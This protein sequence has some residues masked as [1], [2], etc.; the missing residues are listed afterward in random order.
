MPARAVAGRAA[1]LVVVDEFLTALESGPA[2]LILEGEPGI[3]KTTLWQATVELARERGARV[4][5]SRP[6]SSE[7]RLTFAGLGDLLVDVGDD[8]IGALPDP[9]RDALEVALLRADPIGSSSERRVVSTA[10]LGT[11]LLLAAESPVLIA[12]DDLQ[13]LDTASRR[14]LDFAVRRLVGR[15]VGVLTAIRI[16]GTAGRRAFADEGSERIRLGPLSLAS[17]HEVLK[18]ELGRTF[19][20]PTLVRIEATSSGNPFFAV[21]LARALVERGEALHGSAPLPVPDDLADLLATRLRRLPARTR[22]ALLVAATLSAPTLDTIDRASLERAKAAGVVRID[23]R[24][25]VSF[26]HPLLA[27]SVYASAGSGERRAVHAEVADRASSPEE[28]ARHRA[29]AAEEPDDEVATELAAAARTARDRGAPDGAVELLELACDLTPPGERHALSERRLDLGRYLSETGD[30]QRALEVLRDVAD[31]AP[32]GTVRARALLLLAYMTETADAGETANQLCERGLEAATD[33]VELRI[34]ILAAASRMSDHDVE[35]KLAYARDALELAE[36]KGIAPQLLSYALLAVAEA[37]F[38]AGN[39]I[40]AGV[41]ERAAELEVAATAGRSAAPGRSLHRVHHYSDVR[42]SARL[43]GILHIYAD[44]LDGAR[45]EFELERMVA[46]AHGDEVQLARTLVRL[47]LIELRAGRWELAAAHLDEAATVLERTEQAALLRWML[48]TR[49]SLEALRGNVAEAR[50][51]AE[52]A[53]E[54]AVGA[55]ALWGE[56]ECRAALGFLDLSLGDPPSAIVHLSAAAAL[57]ERIGPAEP[58]L[59]RSQADHVEALVVLGQL[60]RAAHEL[61]RLELGASAWAEAT[62]GRCRGLLLS[63]RGDLNAAQAALDAALRAHARLPLPFE[64]A[65]TLLVQGQVHRRRG[66]RR[67]AKDALEL[68]IE[69]FDR[70]GAPTWAETARAEHRRLGL[71]RGPTDELTPSEE[72]VAVLA[73]SGLTNREI[74]ERIF[75]S[76]KTVEANLSRAY[77]KLGIRSRAELGALMTDRANAP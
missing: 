5:T 71:R 39:G 67:L 50:S 30:P 28:R 62:G 59:F 65:R 77:R 72:N 11:L 20:R 52:R 25:R 53:L 33:D 54:L 3:G 1:E 13:W 36:S 46:D 26:A 21:E 63:A 34:E 76:P 58:R 61:S 24:G 75:V 16:D 12:V 17:L 2:A 49:A 60:D 35:R 31:T 57:S 27:A 42:P 6:A 10:F 18:G 70:L 40:A 43:L 37:E 44:E 51:L 15:R 29:L 56:A 7:T 68:S 48:A 23:E 55:G 9:Q 19:P 45:R 64:H 32:A 41:F 14:I 73:A 47:G 38:F 74:A 22:H 4:L 69:L 66:E 8:V